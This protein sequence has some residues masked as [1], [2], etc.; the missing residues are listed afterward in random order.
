MKL[1]HLMNIP[2]RIDN[3]IYTCIT[4]YTIVTQASPLRVSDVPSSLSSL[5]S[6]NGHPQGYG[7]C[8]HTSPEQTGETITED[9]GYRRHVCPP[10]VVVVIRV[11]PSTF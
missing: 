3:I 6:P 11:M 1:R 10:G 5:P 4:C 7:A 2:E 9:S 8:G